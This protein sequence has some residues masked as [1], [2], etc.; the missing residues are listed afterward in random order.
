MYK[1]KY[2]KLT[3]EPR[4]GDDKWWIDFMKMAWSTD[5]G[6]DYEDDNSHH[7]KEKYS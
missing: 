3:K 6:R 4:V 1:Y 7:M 5:Q 2:F